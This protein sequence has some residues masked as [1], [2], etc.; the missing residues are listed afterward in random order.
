MERSCGGRQ[1]TGAKGVSCARHFLSRV[2]LN[3]F[4]PTALVTQQLRSLFACTNVQL[5]AQGIAVQRRALTKCRHRAA[6]ANF[7]T[8]AGVRLSVRCGSYCAR[9]FAK[10]RPAPTTTAERGWDARHS[11]A[12]ATVLAANPR[13][14]P[15]LRSAWKNGRRFHPTLLRWVAPNPPASSRS[16]APGTPAVPLEFS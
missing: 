2:F 12:A 11:P 13:E 16:R 3:F 14:L 4:Y 1:K 15:T 7:Q 9:R 5:V 10:A 8:H 6:A